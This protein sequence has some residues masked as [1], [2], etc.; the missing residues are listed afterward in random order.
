M[1]KVTRY[2][3]INKKMIE[4]NC[5][6]LFGLCEKWKL[7]NHHRWRLA[8]FGSPQTYHFNQKPVFHI[9]IKLNANECHRENKYTKN[10]MTLSLIT[11]KRAIKPW[12]KIMITFS[13]TLFCSFHSLIKNV[14]KPKKIDIKQTI[15]QHFW[16]K[17]FKDISIHSLLW[18]SWLPR[19]LNHHQHH[20]R[21]VLCNTF[22]FIADWD[23]TI[24]L[25]GCHQKFTLRKNRV[26]FWGWKA[27]DC[28]LF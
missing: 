26:P 9:K 19:I 6:F 23:F 5:K 10:C 27:Y 14:R 13:V 2:F 15:E 20:H 21:Q 7:I 12:R 17:I 28:Y 18:G 4:K 24:K 25:L 11:K 8:V 22:F 1:H 16:C 3:E